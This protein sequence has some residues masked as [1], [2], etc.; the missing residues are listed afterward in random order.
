[1]A[2]RPI[3]SPGRPMHQKAALATIL[4][5]N[6]QQKLSHTIG[7]EK[8]APSRCRRGHEKRTRRLVSLGDFHQG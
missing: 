8:R 3:P 5:K 4:H 2:A 6:I 1:M 7:L